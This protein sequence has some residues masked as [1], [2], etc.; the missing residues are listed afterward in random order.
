MKYWKIIICAA[1]L[2]LATVSGAFSASATDYDRYGEQYEQM[3]D[4][5]PSD[6]VELLPDGLYSHDAEQIG[7]AMEQMSSFDFLLSRL[8]D[9]LGV[10]LEDALRLFA[11]LLGL[12]ILSALLRQARTLMRSAALSGAVSFCCTAASMPGPSGIPRALATRG[13][14]L[15]C[16][17]LVRDIPQ[18]STGV[19]SGILWAMVA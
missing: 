10:G 2:A 7:Q 8:A 1:V 6:V 17:A 11:T 19:W 4:G 13:T 18:K 15:G 12:V 9:V 5:I 14:T 16:P 3:L